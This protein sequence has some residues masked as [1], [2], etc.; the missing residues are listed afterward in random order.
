MFRLIRLEWTKTFHKLRTYIGFL[1]ICVVLPL[2]FI[3]LKI[4]QGRF[5]MSTQ[6]YRILQDNFFIGGN[7]LNGLFVSQ[8]IMYLLMVHIPFFIA[9]V[10]GDQVAGEATAGTLRMILIKP[11]SRS[12]ILAAKVAIS[13]VYTILLVLCLA[14]I[15]LGLGIIIFGTGDL[16]VRED[17]LLI[18]SKQQA[19]WRFMIAY[20]LAILAMSVIAALALLLSVLVENAIGPIIG[21]M[22]I[23]VV[24]V[25]ISE[26]PLSLFKKIS[27]FLFTSYTIVWQKAFLD[28]MPL[29]D[30]L[31]ASVYLLLYMSLF[32]GAAFFIFNRRDILS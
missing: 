16:L 24:F 21:T 7:L 14:V 9:L 2:I 22:A 1:S 13:L 8:L 5:M 6:S 15:S 25:M 32:F 31:L 3:G 17:G 11:P 26:I 30:I 28:P 18:L 29:N 10:A 27:P 4:D 19:L 20:P 12:K 23:V